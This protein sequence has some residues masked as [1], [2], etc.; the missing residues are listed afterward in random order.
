MIYFSKIS[1][2]GLG[3]GSKKTPIGGTY[4]EFY[5]IVVFGE[6]NCISHFFIKDIYLKTGVDIV[7]LHTFYNELNPIVLNVTQNLQNYA[8]TEVAWL[9][10]QRARPHI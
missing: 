3:L 1:G 4:F 2:Q 7:N 9:S 5:F 6:K 10:W 8:T